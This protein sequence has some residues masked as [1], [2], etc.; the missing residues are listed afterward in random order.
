MGTILTAESMRKRITH[1]SWCYMHR[2][3]GEDVDSLIIHCRVATAAVGGPELVSK[4]V[5]YAKYSKGSIALLKFQK[6]RG[7]KAY[8]PMSFMWVV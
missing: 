4:T 5:N 1:V 6:K 7:L 3:S 8:S 2:Y